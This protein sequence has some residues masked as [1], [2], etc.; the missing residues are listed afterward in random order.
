MNSEVRFFGMVETI[1][2]LHGAVHS[3]SIFSDWQE[4]VEKNL[5]N[6]SKEEAYYCWPRDTLFRY[7]LIMEN[8]QV[9]KIEKRQTRSN[10]CKIEKCSWSKFYG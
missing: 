6:L 9:C 5:M 1:T 2:L 3:D 10:I 7:L 8:L 4:R